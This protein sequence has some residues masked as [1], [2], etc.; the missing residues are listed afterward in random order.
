[1]FFSVGDIGRKNNDR[2]FFE[3]DLARHVLCDGGRD[4][5]RRFDLIEGG[6]F[7]GRVLVFAITCS[8]E[9]I[10]ELIGSMIMQS[11]L[12]VFQII[13]DHVLKIYHFF[14]LEVVPF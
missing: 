3:T 12:F 11:D 4:V 10:G 7:D 14:P 13:D 5:M 6:A 9:I 1:M 2:S 8:G